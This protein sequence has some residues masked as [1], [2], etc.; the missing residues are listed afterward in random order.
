MLRDRAVLDRHTGLSTS[1]FVSGYEGSPLSGYD[2]ELARR[3]GLFAGLDLVHRPGLNEE[4][5][6]TSVMGTQVAATVAT[7]R[8]D[9]VVGYWYGKAPGLDRATD[10]LRHAN[11]IGTSP[12][13]GAVALVGDDA[14]AKSSTVPS[15]SE[16]ALAD[17]W[18]PTLVPA[19]AQDALDLGV[20]A[21]LLSR[22]SGLW[23]ALK[24]S[25]P[26]ADGASTAQ[27]G[28]DRFDAALAATAGLG[29]SR[30]RPTAAVFGRPLAELE[31][32]LHDVRLPRAVDYLRLAGINRIEGARGGARI[33][34]VAAGTTWL[35]VRE[36]LRLLGIRDE[37]LG[38]RGIRLLK[39]GAVWPLEP[40]IVREFA[41]G[42]AEIVV[43]EEKRS[44]VESGI[45]DLLYGRADAPVV[46]GRTDERGDR[47][48]T[49]IGDLDVDAVT[50]GLAS[51]LGMP[52]APS[53]E[54]IRMPSLP[55]TPTPTL[56]AR[57]PYFCSGCPHN[58]STKVPD[59]TLVGGGI[60]CHALVLLMDP[61]Q[62]GTVTG[63][64]QMGGE[65]S[66][67]IGMSPFVTEGHI[68]QNIGDGTFAHSGSL[69]VRAAI[70][71]G[72]NLT[73][74]L[75]FN[76]TVA[77]TGGQDPVGAM[78]LDQ[79]CRVLLAEGVA[80]IVVT[81]DDVERLS[82]AGLPA[83]V[84][85]RPRADVVEVQRELAAVPGVTVLVHDQACATEQRRRR[86][87]G[88]VAPAATR[89]WINERICEGCGDCGEKSNCLS[90]HPVDTAFGRKTRIHQSSC[91][92]DASCLAGDC[93]SFVTV[94]PGRPVERDR[95]ADLA[96]DAIPPPVDETVSGAADFAMRITGIGGTGV[97]TVS[98]IL[99]T[100]AVLEGRHARALDQTGAA[101]KGG[102]VVGDVRVTAEPVECS[103]KIPAGGAD[104]YLVCDELV[105]ADPRNL[106][107]ASPQRTVAVVSSTRT[108]TGSMVVD[109]GVTY[110]QADSVAA[111]LEPAMRRTLR[112]DPA[113]LSMQ[114]FGSAQYANLVLVGVAYQAGALPIGAAAIEQAIELNGVSVHANV[115]AFRRGR[116]S[117]ADPD[118]L[119]SA[120]ALAH[121]G[122]RVAGAR[123][124]H[125]KRGGEPPAY[126]S[127]ASLAELVAHRRAELVDY[128][129]ERYAGRYA[130]FVEQ[131]RA[132]ESAAV[133]GSERLARAVAHHLHK[134]MAYKDEYE[135]ARLATLPEV[136]AEL[137]DLFGS[138]AQASVML[139]PPM[140]RALGMQRKLALGAAAR[141]VLERLASLKSL[142]GRPIDPFGKAHVR[143]VERRLI[144]D[145]HDTIEA[146]LPRIS[147]ATL[148][149]LVE[150]A[151]LPDLIR[152]YEE[153]KLRT[154]ERYRTALATA[155]RE[156]PTE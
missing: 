16:L 145:Y 132:A 22:A 37:E 58:T 128:Q 18:M 146:L 6:A 99:A 95:V 3:A 31:R 96:D 1:T 50:T 104:L 134:L 38:S 85:V 138:D 154:V 139:H 33:G 91:N 57:T 113:G 20:H 76:G 106:V 150:I 63:L 116:Q 17:L 144:R 102:A 44:F 89:V 43:V 25:V 60:G 42:L 129:D 108:P 81:G 109:T 49:P 21:A 125:G 119:V 34:I 92:V 24:I 40:G 51:R 10:A 142:R 83:G 78:T 30:H 53:A 27:V 35:A 12:T 111:V 72:A 122:V 56:A 107:V 97:V 153:I 118:S 112:L 47:L 14:G 87:R 117:V 123:A 147:P 105:G 7:L 13:G 45:R 2:Q 151:E 69:A 15:G 5:A 133:P 115:Q 68:V 155:L 46:V 131:V 84:D 75:L 156:L 120:I 114:C 19:D 98:Q 4:I 88:T 143:R 82:A 130:A 62:V 80:R 126:R 90:V 94:V 23:A 36:A 64:T 39:L 71:S 61:K 66:Q 141:P 48:F 54:P 29:P 77:M 137:A 59:G 93:P 73:Y 148:D 8:P 124:G 152:G 65:G 9:G 32:S 135:V 52:P 41:D 140:L 149:A 100:A 86:K 103:P 101:Q 136:Q 11:I 74:K 26:M 28:L 79:V 70:A 127:E 121:K 67:W 110:P 55:I